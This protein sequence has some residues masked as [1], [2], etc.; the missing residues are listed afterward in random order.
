MSQKRINELTKRRD[1]LILLRDAETTSPNRSQD[2]IDDLN[3]SITSCEN[4]IKY[5]K[6]NTT[7]PN[8][9]NGW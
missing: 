7:P 1:S 2:Y 5:L 8:I 3:L 6:E 4:Q 9:M